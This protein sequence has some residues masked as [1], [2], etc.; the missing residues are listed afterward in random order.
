MVKQN[1]LIVGCGDLG[2][3]L[4]L[5]LDTSAY[6]IYGLCRSHRALPAPIQA[7][8]GDISDTGVAA[9]LLERRTYDVIVVTL[10]PDQ[11]DDEG[12]RRA[13]VAPMQAL[14][15]GL[16]R[17]AQR[18]RLLI[19]VSSTSVYGHNAGEWV[20]E[21]S[22]TEPRAFN[23]RRLLQAEQLLLD[24]ELGGCVV[25]FSGIYGRAR[26]YLIQQVRDG[27]GTPKQ[28]AHYSNRIHADDCAG[29][30]A[31]LIEISRR[32][33]ALA[34]LYLASDCEPAPLWE[35]KQWLAAQLQLPEGHLQ[36]GTAAQRAEGAPARAATGKRCSNKRL[37]ASGYRFL[38]PSYRSGY[39]LKSP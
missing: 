30:L 32:G 26:P 34:P 37:L 35:V 17:R 20:D 39:R 19:F 38:H 23:G 21:S 29:V 7:L 15:G 11:R 9:E 1:L 14:V 33:Q 36:A 13:Y 4:A 25:R 8:R 3:R 28:P 16:E 22:A 24:T 6:T 31:H 2:G 12:Y 5:R 27:V 18:P 10:T